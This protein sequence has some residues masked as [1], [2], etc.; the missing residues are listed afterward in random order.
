M[1]LTSVAG[2][3][4]APEVGASWICEPPSAPLAGDSSSGPRGTQE[5]KGEGTGGK[6]VDD[7]QLVDHL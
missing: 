7:G 2:G 5:S 1:G 6:N 4:R 3:L